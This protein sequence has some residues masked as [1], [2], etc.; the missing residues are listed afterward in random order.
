MTPVEIKVLRT[1]VPYDVRDCMC[2]KLLAKYRRGDRSASDVLDA[3]AALEAQNLQEEADAFVFAALHA[4]S[5]VP[6]ALWTKA[7]N[8]AGRWSTNRVRSMLA[9]ARKLPR[10]RKHLPTRDIVKTRAG[11]VA[12]LYEASSHRSPWSLD[13]LDKAMA[14]LKG[15]EINSRATS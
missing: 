3:V 2:G 9:I 14:H 11:A 8:C 5:P 10:C 6:T 7:C 1:F 13:L 4:I 12:A 15:D